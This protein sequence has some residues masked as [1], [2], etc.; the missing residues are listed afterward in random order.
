MLLLLI[1]RVE[2]CVAIKM[3]GDVDILAHSS[4]ANA[5]SVALLFRPWPAVHLIA[6]KK[7]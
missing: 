6:T 1:T 2:H 4:L 3:I 7:D 5:F